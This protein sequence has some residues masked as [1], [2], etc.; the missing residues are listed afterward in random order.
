[1]RG[2]PIVKPLLGSAP[3]RAED[4]GIDGRKT[5]DSLLEILGPR[6]SSE[7]VFDV[8]LVVPLLSKP[9]RDL[10]I[11]LVI[12][13]DPLVARRRSKE[14]LV[15]AVQPLELDDWCCVVIDAEVNNPVAHAAVPATSTNHQ[16]RCRLLATAV[17][18]GSL[19][20]G[21]AR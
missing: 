14:E 8:G 19:R 2:L 21:E 1:M 18:S 4:D 11:E 12:Y 6:P 10:R 20:R 17:P 5:F 9:A 7:R 13:V 3:K 15:E 16:K